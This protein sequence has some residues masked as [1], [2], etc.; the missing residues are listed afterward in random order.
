[1]SDPAPLP[2][3]KRRPPPIFWVIIILLVILLAIGIGSLAY[4]VRITYG[5]AP[6]LWAKPWEMPEPERI[7]A[8]LAV[9]SLA[10][11]EPEKVYQFAMAG[12][13][14]DTVAALALLTPRLSP[15]QR[16]GWLDVLAQRFR[17]VGR[18]EDARVFLRYT[19]DLAM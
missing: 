8:G 6:A 1:M 3:T 12:E 10:G 16:L 9:W 11:T 7:N 14:L 17:V 19:T 13:E 4:Y 18:N 2:A 5:P 15:A